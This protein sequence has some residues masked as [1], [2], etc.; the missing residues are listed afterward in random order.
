MP[1]LSFRL[2]NS[3]RV[4]CYVPGGIILGSRETVY[5]RVKDRATWLSLSD[6]ETDLFGEL[7]RQLVNTVRVF[8][9]HTR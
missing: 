7:Q 6:I 1:I 5:V 3:D 4:V 9:V 2:V 8:G